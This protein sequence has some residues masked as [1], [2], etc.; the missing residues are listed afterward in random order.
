MFVRA[1]VAGAFIR[2]LEKPFQSAPPARRPTGLKKGPDHF[3]ANGKSDGE[4]I[5]PSFSRETTKG[6]YIP[7]A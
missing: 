4:H 2:V 3:H 5:N 6:H 7:R 1:I